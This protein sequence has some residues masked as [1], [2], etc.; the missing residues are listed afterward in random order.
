MRTPC[1]L[2]GTR[3]ASA[4]FVKTRGDS[5]SPKGRTCTDM[6]VLRTQTTGMACGTEGSHMEVWVFQ[7][8]C[9]RPNLGTDASEDTV[10]HEHLERRFMKGPVQDAQTQDWS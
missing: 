1:S 7:V 4:T 3:A 8:K 6:L 5:D 10:L 2:K 9:C